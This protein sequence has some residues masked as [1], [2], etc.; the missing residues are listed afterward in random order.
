MS[1]RKT[2]SVVPGTWALARKYETT[3]AIEMPYTHSRPA[4]FHKTGNEP[5]FRVT[6]ACR[7][8]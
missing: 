3:R 5:L 1:S 6:S 4:Y 8:D 7:A 2:V